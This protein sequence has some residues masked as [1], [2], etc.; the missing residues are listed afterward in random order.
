MCSSI[1]SVSKKDFPIE[2]RAVPAFVDRVVL[3]TSRFCLE[4]GDI[5]QTSLTDGIRATW[6]DITRG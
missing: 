2:E 4:F 6:E 1:R 3:D 5:A